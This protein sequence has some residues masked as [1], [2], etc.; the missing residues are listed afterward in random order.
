M[1]KLIIILL[2]GSVIKV[3][4]Q[5]EKPVVIMSDTKGWH[6]IGETTVDFKTETEEI[7]PFGADRFAFIK[8]KIED[9]PID[10]ISLEIYYESG[11][12]QN[13]T[14]GKQIKAPGESRTVQ[15][16]GGERTLKF[17]F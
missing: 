3:A 7:I 12:S 2:M 8:F 4:A 5:K 17:F 14:I 1:K 11:D 15:L 10:L 6:K 9:A 16:N 13:V